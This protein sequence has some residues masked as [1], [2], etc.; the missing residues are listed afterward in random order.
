MRCND[1]CSWP[2]RRLHC[3]LRS[4][5]RRSQRH[6]LPRPITTIKHTR[7]TTTATIDWIVLLPFFFMA[8]CVLAETVRC[9]L[10]TQI[11]Q[12]ISIIIIGSTAVST[13]TRAT[14]CRAPLYR[15]AT[16]AAA[17]GALRPF[18]VSV[19]V[20]RGQVLI[21]FA[22]AHAHFWG[23]IEA[24]VFG[25]LL[26]NEM[27]L[28]I[29]IWLVS[30]GILHHVS[31]VSSAEFESC[32]CCCLGQRKIFIDFRCKAGQVSVIYFMRYFTTLFDSPAGAAS[33][34]H[35]Q[36]ICITHTLSPAACSGVQHVQ[37]PNWLISRAP[38]RQLP[39]M[40]MLLCR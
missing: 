13:C 11:N 30:G 12:F 23:L 5:P 27:V 36:I 22:K 40:K 37:R 16:A 31:R 18:A 7:A 17:A 4:L 24:Y 33:A 1:T 21:T 32:C 38:A 9:E 6:T 20:A 10:A 15:P 39:C 34:A 8:L 14:P 35:L 25:Q 26:K 28:H 29:V 3:V 2:Y 19:P